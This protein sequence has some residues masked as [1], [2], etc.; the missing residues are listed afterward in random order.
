MNCKDC[1]CRFALSLEL[2]ALNLELCE[3]SPPDRPLR[4]PS[5][6]GGAEASH[7]SQKDVYKAASG[8]RQARGG[9]DSSRSKRCTA[10]GRCSSSASTCGRRS[11]GFSSKSQRTR[12]QHRALGH[13]KARVLNRPHQKALSSLGLN[14]P[15]IR[16]VQSVPLPGAHGIWGGCRQQ[17]RW[18]RSTPLGQNRSRAPA[19]RKSTLLRAELRCSLGVPWPSPSES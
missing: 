11:Q 6:A 18:A 12:G 19:P 14:G 8:Q 9:L 1:R 7:R 2:F 16:G 17:P 4:R 5:R 3:A 13:T 10:R 15:A